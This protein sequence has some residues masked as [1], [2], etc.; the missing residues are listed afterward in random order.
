MADT[1]SADHVCPLTDTVNAKAGK[2][3]R[4]TI[5]ATVTVASGPGR[6]TDRTAVEVV[7]TGLRAAQCGWR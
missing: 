3:L 1:V 4:Y 5:Q 7:M 2:V 6:E